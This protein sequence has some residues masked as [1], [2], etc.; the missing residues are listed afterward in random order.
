VS[1]SIACVFL[2][3]SLWDAGRYALVLSDEA[4]HAMNGALIHDWLAGGP[5]LHPMTYALRYFSRWP[6][7][8]MPYHPPLFPIFEA[9]IYFWLGVNTFAARVAVGLALASLVIFFC[10]PW[11][12]QLSRQ[13]ML[14]WPALALLT[15]AFLVL[16]RSRVSFSWQ[17][18]ISFALLAGAAVWTKQEA[19]FAGAV[20]VLYFLLSKRWS[21]LSS[22]GV[23]VATALFGLLVVGLDAWTPGGALLRRVG[24]LH[25]LT[26][27]LPHNIRVYLTAAWSLPGVLALLALGGLMARFVLVRKATDENALYWS[28][29]VAAVPVL[30]VGGWATDRYLFIV[31]P[32]IVVPGCAMLLRSLEAVIDRR[33]GLWVLLAVAGIYAAGHLRTASQSLPGPVESAQVVIAQGATRVLYCGETD[34][35]FIFALRSIGGLSSPIVIR[36]QKLSP[37]VFTAAGLERFA[38]DYGISHVVLERTDVR[39]IWDDLDVAQVRWLTRDRDIRLGGPTGDTLRVYR[40]SDPS[41]TPLKTLIVPTSKLEGVERRMTL[42]WSDPL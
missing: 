37:D 29:A 14:E 4:R 38:H 23:W 6:A 34:G 2:V 41:P 22:P 16:A 15:M 27:R 11:S 7:L 3:C 33:V 28:W 32:A 9:L 1:G 10:T 13:V 35:Q 21:V 19:V 17:Q 5:W 31:L 20:P 24:P 8:S 18:G 12:Q 39:Q 42:D 30:L 36:G 40:F 25:E 26:G